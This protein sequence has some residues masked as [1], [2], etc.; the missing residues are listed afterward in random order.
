MHRAFFTSERRNLTKSS[1]DAADLMASAGMLVSFAQST[2]I[3]RGVARATLDEIDLAGP[4]SARNIAEFPH[5]AR[6]SDDTIA[7]VGASKPGRDSPTRKF[8]ILA[9][10]S[11]NVRFDLRALF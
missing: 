9:F 11:L 8:F 4:I 5:E 3:D 6:V 1:R 2:P 10:Q 7:N